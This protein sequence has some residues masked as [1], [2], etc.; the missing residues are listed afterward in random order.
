MEETRS[1]QGKSSDTEQVCVCAFKCA[2]R[3]AANAKERV[4]GH[5]SFMPI[6]TP[7]CIISLSLHFGS[8]GPGMRLSQLSLPV[9]E[10]RF[11]CTGGKN[12]PSAKTLLITPDKTPPHL[13]G[14]SEGE[15]KCMTKWEMLM[16]WAFSCLL[17]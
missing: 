6:H 11:S 9:T 2:G 14:N 4:S 10:L 15:I 17:L 7:I 13:T 5:A 1:Q 16:I 3:H 8:G 12:A